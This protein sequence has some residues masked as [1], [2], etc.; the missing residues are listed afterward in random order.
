MAADWRIRRCAAPGEE[1]WLRMREALWPHSTREQHLVE[2][3][4]WCTDPLRYAVFLAFDP[5][6]D[7][8]GF[9]EA[10]IRIDHVNGTETSPVGF[11]EGIYVA[12]AQ[13]KQGIARALTEKVE[14]WAAFRGCREMA[15]DADIDNVP[16]HRM[17]LAL[18]FEQTEQVVYF[19]KWI[20]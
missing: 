10:A 19:R 11:L 15:S 16:S 13:R 1:G 5:A 20:R 18:G 17:H 2:M 12:P 8:V 9:A 14:S 7:V 3:H 6:G 4:Q